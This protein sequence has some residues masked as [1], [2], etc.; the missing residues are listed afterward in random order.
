[1]R[2][3]PRRGPSLRFCNF[4]LPPVVVRGDM[5]PVWE[6]WSLPTILSLPAQLGREGGKVQ[7]PSQSHPQHVPALAPNCRCLI[8]DL[9]RRLACPLHYLRKFLSLNVTGPPHMPPT[10]LVA[11][12]PLH[13]LRASGFQVRGVHMQPASGLG[14]HSGGG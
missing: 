3:Q 12:T 5:Q 14:F 2:T 8:G 9:W 6:G 11:D 10:C 1:M 7:N 4:H 13:S